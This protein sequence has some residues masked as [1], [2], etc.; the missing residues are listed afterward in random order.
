MTSTSSRFADYKARSNR[1]VTH[2]K[3]HGAYVPGAE[4]DPDPQSP[5]GGVSSSANDMAKWLAFVL[6]GGRQLVDRSVLLQAMSPQVVSRP[7]ANF[8]ERAS[9]Y[10]DGFNVGTSA[11]GRV[12]ISHSVRSYSA[13]ARPTC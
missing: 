9:F 1:A 3:M 7:P 10:G 12:T 11:S 6:A 8:N 4:R 2:V 5:A 13:P